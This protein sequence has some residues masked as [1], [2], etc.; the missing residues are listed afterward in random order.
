MKDSPPA[1]SQWLRL[2]EAARLLSMSEDGLRKALER[3]AV[4]APDGVVEAEM[5]GVRGRKLGRGWRVRLGAR[6]V[7]G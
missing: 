6:W 1:T 5:D 3:R 7:A 2:S 4:L